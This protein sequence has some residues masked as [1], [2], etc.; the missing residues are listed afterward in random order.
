MPQQRK[1]LR[2]C[3]AGTTYS[4][5]FKATRYISTAT[6]PPSRHSATH[7]PLHRGGLA[8]V[9]LVAQTIIFSCGV[10]QAI[11]IHRE[12]SIL[13]FCERENPAAGEGY[14]VSARGLERREVEKRFYLK[15]CGLRQ[16][17][18]LVCTIPVCFEQQM[19]KI[20]TKCVENL[21][22]H[23]I[24]YSRFPFSM[25]IRCTSSTLRPRSCASF[26]AMR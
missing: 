2:D 9:L 1:S 11:M 19:T 14:G 6:T 12:A 23:S 10:I 20:R 18:I 8:A 17:L 13:H 4:Q 7:P 26:S 25:V 24:R 16:P 15:D 5:Q 21:N 22:Y 3:V